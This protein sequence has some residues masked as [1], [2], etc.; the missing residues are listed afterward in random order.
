MVDF[1]VKLTVK[2]VNLRE[3]HS[4]RNWTNLEMSS[5]EETC[6]S[7]R[8]LAQ[9]GK[10]PTGRSGSASP[11]V[12]PQSFSPEKDQ[13]VKDQD[14]GY[15]SKHSEPEK[16]KEVYWNPPEIQIDND[17]ATKSFL[18]SKLTDL[19]SM[20]DKLK[21]RLNQNSQPEPEKDKNSSGSNFAS[22]N[23]GLPSFSV[24]SL[25]P[26][27]FGQNVTSTSASNRNLEFQPSNPSLRGF[28]MSQAASGSEPTGTSQA[29]QILTS[30]GS[31]TPQTM[32]ASQAF[33]ASIQRLTSQGY[34]MQG[35]VSGPGLTFPGFSNPIVTSQTFTNLSDSAP[36]VTIP[37]SATSSQN[38]RR[39]EQNLERLVEL[40][41][42]EEDQVRLNK[43]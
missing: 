9:V 28:G 43:T 2:P 40:S 17:T 29:S 24:D 30:Q 3:V 32:T 15:K 10:E 1:Q 38:V 21:A 4:R 5:D 36:R 19:T 33:A 18:A 22:Q 42:E 20:A 7:H 34:A 37:Q 16:E 14:S 23:I 39:P 41:D 27:L 31:A 12:F 6:S 11:K 26:S 25:N 13:P 35:V 8:N